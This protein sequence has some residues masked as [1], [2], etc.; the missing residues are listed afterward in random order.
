MAISPYK[1]IAM[2]AIT[3]PGGY[4]TALILCTAF[5]C[6]LRKLALPKPIP[7]IPYD[8]ESAT[9]VFGDLPA[10]AR[11][12]NHREWIVSH[13]IKLQ[14][15]IFQVF[16]RPFTKPHVFVTDFYEIADISMRRI[17]EF[18]ISNQAIGVFEGIVPEQQITLHSADP[19]FKKNRELVR[20]LMSP[21]FLNN[22]CLSSPQ[23]G[24]LF[25]QWV[26]KTYTWLGLSAAYLRCRC[27]SDGPLG[28]ETCL[29]Q[30]KTL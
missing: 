18:D 20:D 30:R 12:A 17:K 4:A 6:I 7:G 5:L 23:N 21:K 16:A 15:P 14:S 8:P 24:I 29:V 26:A 9:K 1:D 22:V 28:K 10:L 2:L 27:T 25:R 19:R 13:G 11:A 3:S